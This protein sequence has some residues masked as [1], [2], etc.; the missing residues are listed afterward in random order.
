MRIEL[1]DIQIKKMRIE[2]RK[3]SGIMGLRGSG[4]VEISLKSC[5][6]I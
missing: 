6:Q 2:T 4:Y 1:P 3:I 5:K